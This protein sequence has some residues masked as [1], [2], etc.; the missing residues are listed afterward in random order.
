MEPDLKQQWRLVP[1]EP[2][3]KM[4]RAAFDTLEVQPGAYPTGTAARNAVYEAMLA[5]AP[6]PTEW[7][8]KAQELLDELSDK[9][10]VSV[11][12]YIDA[13]RALATHL[14]SVRGPK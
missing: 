3:E 13:K 14:A 8:E 6:D 5:A 12:E 1:V 11:P 2:D 7:L 10:V 9:V 4:Q